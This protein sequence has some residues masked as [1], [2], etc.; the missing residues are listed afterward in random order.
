[1]EPTLAKELALDALLMTLVRRQPRAPISLTTS[2]SSTIA[3]DVTAIWVASVRRRSSVPPREATERSPAPGESSYHQY[4]EGIRCSCLPSTLPA[5][6]NCATTCHLERACLAAKQQCLM[7]WL[8]G[9]LGI[10]CSGP[11]RAPLTLGY[12]PCHLAS[13]RVTSG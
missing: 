4:D 11:L 12:S 2:R 9:L 5:T 7:P 10:R 8:R 13:T 6:R 1:M 3:I